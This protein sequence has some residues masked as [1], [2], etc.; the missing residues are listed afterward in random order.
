MREFH[1]KCVEFTLFFPAAPLVC[2]LFPRF[3]ANNWGGIAPA[4]EKIKYG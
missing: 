3:Y 1:A 2:V 4:K